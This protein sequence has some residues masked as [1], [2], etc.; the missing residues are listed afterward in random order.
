M[1]RRPMTR[2]GR[3]RS[4]HF[5][6]PPSGAARCTQ[7]WSRELAAAAMSHQTGIQGNGAGAALGEGA[8]RRPRA[9]RAGPESGPKHW[10]C[11][12]GASRASESLCA[13]VS[14]TLSAC[15]PPFPGPAAATLRR[16][17]KFAGAKQVGPAAAGVKGAC[18]QPEPT[19]TQL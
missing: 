19:L 10:E 1:G 5:L 3:R 16:D 15:L 6:E 17:P 7:R 8:P 12:S 4:G 2:R 9:G 13:P 18:L 11:V 14:R